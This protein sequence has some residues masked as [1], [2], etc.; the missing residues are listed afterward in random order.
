MSVIAKTQTAIGIHAPRREASGPL[1]SDEVKVSN[2]R[3]HLEINVEVPLSGKTSS[4]QSGERLEYLI[5][6]EPC[7]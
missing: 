3:F 2:R 6:A 5:S 1:L 7:V 4:I